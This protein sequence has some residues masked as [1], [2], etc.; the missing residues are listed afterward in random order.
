MHVAVRSSRVSPHVNGGPGFS[1]CSAITVISLAATVGV[2]AAPVPSPS[3]LAWQRSELTIFCHFGMNTFTDREWGNGKE[4]PTLFSLSSLDCGQW[5]ATAKSAGFK[6]IILTA[7][8]HDGFCLWPSKVTDH[9]VAHSTWKDGKG[10]VVREFTDACHAAGVKVGLYLSPWDMHEPSYGTDAYNDFF[11]SQLTELLTDYGAVD[12]VWFDGALGKGANGQ[13]QNFDWKRH[14][15]LIRRLQPSALISITGPDVRWAGNESGIARPGLSSIQRARPGV[16]FGKDP[17]ARVWYPAECDVSIRPGWF[18]HEKQ[19]GQVKSL[20]A[21]MDIY[22]QSVGRNCVL[23]LN[24][25]PD[26]RGLIADSDAKRLQEFGDAV[27]ALYTNKVAEAAAGVEADF[28]DE[29]TFNLVSVSEDIAKGERVKL[30][31][32]EARTTNGWTQ[33]SSGTVVGQR[34]LHQVAPLTAT[35]I[36]LVVGQSE[37]APLVSVSVYD[38][39]QDRR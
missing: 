4:S 3:Q 35:A 29:K 11:A 25:P 36:R 9:T 31:R 27:Q 5:V 8:H 18:Y 12:D 28:G 21:L 26:R 7:K 39:A 13:A 23:L 32:V 17:Q 34:Q 33:V 10:D 15:D 30:Y 6:M 16:H 22:Y 38:A 1:V 19:D 24:V 20:S 14:Y 2:S 37:G